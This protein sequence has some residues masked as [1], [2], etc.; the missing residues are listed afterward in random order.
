M[1]LKQR[2][3]R[4]SRFNPESGCTECLG[5][6]TKDGYGL[7]MDDGKK[8]LAHRVVWEF[9]RGPVPDGLCVLHSCDNPPCVTPDHLF[10]GTIQ[11]NNSDKA[12][13]GRGRVGA[14]GLPFGVTQRCRRFAAHIRAGGREIHLG[15]FATIDEAHKV[16]LRA[17]EIAHQGDPKAADL[18]ALRREAMQS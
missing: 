4:R 18:A 3:A 7:I 15:T 16:A 5:M 10:L 1:T 11:I 8:L 13:K 14:D 6:H 9:V 12:K 17:R 2:L